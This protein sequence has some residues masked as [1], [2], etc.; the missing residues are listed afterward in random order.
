MPDRFLIESA[1]PNPFNPSTTLRFA[2][3]VE[4]NVEVRLVNTAGQSVRT[5][6]N[7][8]VAA[9]DMQQ[10]TVDAATLPSG[11]Y[12]VHFNGRGISATETIVLTK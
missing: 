3:S 6:Y 8:T 2:V 4:Q 9:N 10:V 11:T 1:Y 5:L 7:G 12:L